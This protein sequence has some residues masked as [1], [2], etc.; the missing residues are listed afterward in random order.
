MRSHLNETKGLSHLVEFVE[1]GSGLASTHEEHR[2]R[3]RDVLL[4][5]GMNRDQVASQGGAEGARSVGG[6]RG[7]S[8]CVRWGA[9][10]P[11]PPALD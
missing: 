5:V 7:S 2:P 4:R 11:A 3:A 1:V 8:C 10:Q 6:S 9:A